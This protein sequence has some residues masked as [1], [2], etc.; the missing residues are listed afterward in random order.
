MEK[1]IMARGITNWAIC[2][3]EPKRSITKNTN[4]FPTRRAQ[5][6]IAI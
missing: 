1:E 2:Q 3:Y 4:K 5:T 6:E